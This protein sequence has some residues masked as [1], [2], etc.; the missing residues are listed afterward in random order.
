MCDYIN[1]AN[2][3]KRTTKCAVAGPGCTH[4]RLIQQIIKIKTPSLINQVRFGTVI[5]FHGGEVRGMF[6]FWQKS[7]T[8]VKVW[9][10]IRGNFVNE[11]NNLKYIVFESQL[12]IH[13]VGVSLGVL[14]STTAVQL[15][16]CVLYI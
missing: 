10:N 9:V 3:L 12:V 13:P 4:L 1:E 15:L 16:K 8:F 14:S 7:L 2:N 11:A 5:V 6:S